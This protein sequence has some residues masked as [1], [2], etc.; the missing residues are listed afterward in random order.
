[1]QYLSSAQNSQI[2]RLK[3]LQ[4]KAKKRKAEKAFVI[5]GFKEIAHAINGGYDIETLFLKEGEEQHPLINKTAVGPHDEYRGR[6]L[7]AFK[8]P[9]S[10]EGNPWPLHNTG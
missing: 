8:I 5:E 1:M 3:A 9:L 4:A 10:G 7:P 6:P 2:K